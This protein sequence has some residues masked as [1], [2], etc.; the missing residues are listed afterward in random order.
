M[1]ECSCVSTCSIDEELLVSIADIL[2]NVLIAS[3]VKTSVS[4]IVSVVCFQ[5]Y[6]F[7]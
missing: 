5:I 1:A 2:D 4:S 7:I 3:I 6:V